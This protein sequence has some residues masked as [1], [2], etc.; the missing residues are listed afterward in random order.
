MWEGS[1]RFF[2]KSIYYHLTRSEEVKNYKHIWK[3]KILEKIKVFLW[4]L[5]NQAIL[6]KDNMVNIKWNGDP[7]CYFWNKEET[8]DHLM[9]E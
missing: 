9:F 5:E 7:G 4:L 8:P 2:V 1:D 3:A 6:T